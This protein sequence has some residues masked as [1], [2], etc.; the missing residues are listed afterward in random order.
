MNTSG[1]P[2]CHRRGEAIAEVRANELDGKRVVAVRE[3]GVELRG[4]RVHLIPRRV[5]QH[6]GGEIRAEAGHL[7]FTSGLTMLKCTP[8]PAHR[9][10]IS[11]HMLLLKKGDVRGN[12]LEISFY[13]G[14]IP[15]P[16]SSK[17]VKPNFKNI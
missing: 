14:S 3:D 15:L 9:E 6:A 13:I 10:C 1:M 12:A 2:G 4:G 17:S 5:D 7:R 16:L 11:L 8:T